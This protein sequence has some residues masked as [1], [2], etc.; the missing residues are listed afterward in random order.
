[1]KSASPSSA[2]PKRVKGR[3]RRLAPVIAEPWY[4]AKL[5]WPLVC[6]ALLPINVDDLQAVLRRF[7]DHLGRA[8]ERGT[9]P[10]QRDVIQAILG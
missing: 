2:N 8:N 9:R 10:R 6:A 3:T 4:V 5:V 1:M 7:V